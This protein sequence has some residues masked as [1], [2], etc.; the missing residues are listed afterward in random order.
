[1]FIALDRQ[2]F[3]VLFAIPNAVVL[4]VYN[5][6]GGCMWPRSSSVILDGV[7]VFVLWNIPANS[8]SSANETTC[9]KIFARIKND[10]L[11]SSSLL[12]PR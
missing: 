10:A 9:F 5:G 1:M 11:M 4:S 2:C 6:V 3:V 7:A 8:D 12:L